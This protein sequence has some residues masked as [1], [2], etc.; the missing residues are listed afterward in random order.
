VAIGLF[1][2]IFLMVPGLQVVGAALLC[3]PSRR[4][5]RLPRLRRSC[6]CP[7]QSSSSFFLRR[8]KSEIDSAIARSRDGD[9]L[10]RAWRDACRM[11]RVGESDAALAIGLGLILLR[12]Q[13][14]CSVM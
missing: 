4:T 5:S 6:R 1:V 9:G 10:Y 11:A 14:P 8:P 7:R 3:L 13:L 12:W 2:G